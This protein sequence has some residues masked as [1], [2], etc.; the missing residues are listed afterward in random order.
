MRD[1]Q[2]NAAAWLKTRGR[3]LLVHSNGHSEALGQS[4]FL[5]C[6]ISAL[7]QES[8]DQDLEHYHRLSVRHRDSDGGHCRRL[9]LGAGWYDRGPAL[10]D[11]TEDAT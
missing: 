10:H 6:W 3:E 7:N 11:E 5:H 9:N 2:F 4:D 8:C 1:P